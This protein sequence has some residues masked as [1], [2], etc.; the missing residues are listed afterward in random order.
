MHA[1]RAGEAA[2]SGFEQSR[3]QAYSPLSRNSCRRDGHWRSFAPLWRATICLLQLTGIRGLLERI[4]NT[5]PGS[6]TSAKTKPEQ[7][8]I[9]PAQDSKPTAETKMM[10][11]D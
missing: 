11:A 7:D 3:L 8:K 10:V 5:R 4:H 6:E 9:K 1:L 2:K